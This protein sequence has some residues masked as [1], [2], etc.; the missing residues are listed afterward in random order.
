MQRSFLRRIAR[1]PYGGRSGLILIALLLFL[2][3]MVVGHRSGMQSFNGVV[4]QV[5]AAYAQRDFAQY[6]AASQIARHGGDPYAPEGVLAV[7]RAVGYTGQYP[8]MM[9]NP[10]WLI[11]LLSPFFLDWS[12]GAAALLWIVF[13][14]AAMLIVVSLILDL[15]R[16]PPGAHGKQAESVSRIVPPPPL[17][18]AAALTF[19]PW[20]DNLRSGQLGTFLLLFAVI[21]IWCFANRRDVLCGAAWAVLSVKAHLFLPFFAALAVIILSARRWRIALSALLTTG[22]L[23][24][25]ADIFYPTLSGRWLSSLIHTAD[26]TKVISVFEWRSETFVA[27]LRGIVYDLTGERADSLMLWLPL[28]VVG[29]TL[30]IT[31]FKLRHF[32]HWGPLLMLLAI[33]VVAAPYG[34]FSDY[35]LVLPLQIV[36]VDRLSTAGSARLNPTALLPIIVQL[37]LIYSGSFRPLVHEYFFVLTLIWVMIVAR[38]F[39]ASAT[40]KP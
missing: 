17:L 27:W 29:A 16:R 23:V 10:P 22:L 38:Y 1:S 31:S 4:E 12:F 8:V 6:Y 14:V 28:V 11:L 20:L 9:W 21:G 37:A 26:V 15:A 40:A 32:P 3:A 13:N 7:Q 30:F 24:L 18:I 33:S 35:T 25:L 34:W 19:Y 36:L 5:A 39:R 2:S